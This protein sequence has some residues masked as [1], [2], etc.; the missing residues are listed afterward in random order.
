MNRQGRTRAAVAE[1]HILTTLC[2]RVGDLPG[3]ATEL[4]SQQLDDLAPGL[5]DAGRERLIRAAVARLEGLDQLEE[6]LHDPAV[7]EILVNRA[8][9]VWIDRNGRLQPALAISADSLEVVIERIL[10]PL[11]RRLDRSSPI[12]DARL[13]DGAR[14]CAVVPP[15]AVDGTCLSIRRVRHRALCLGD[16]GPPAMVDLLTALLTARRTIVIAGGTS[17][18]KTSLLG[19]LLGMLPT[20]ERVILL[21]DT[22]EIAIDPTRHVVRLEA[23]SAQRGGPAAVSLEDLV[24]TA[25]RL[26]PDRIVIGEVRGPE[27]MGLI[28]AINTGH[29]GALSTCHANS[30]ADAVARIETLM[31]QASP[32]WPLAVIRSRIERGVDAVVHLSREPSGSGGARQVTEICEVLR[33]DERSG[34]DGITL[35]PLYRATNTTQ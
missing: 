24:R 25:L 31:M 8:G 11:G 27:V 29:E 6:L 14:V 19:V 28:Q 12:V 17:A 18:G 13:P 9:Q 33:T 20:S 1:A 32:Q 2:E 16:F 35:R 26:R 30:A 4:V 10:A 22:A 15:V 3:D 5:R 21:E 23:R 7:D 34:T